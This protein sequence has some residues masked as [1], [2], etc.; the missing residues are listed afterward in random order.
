MESGLGAED[1]QSN[2]IIQ[3]VLILVLVESGLGGYGKTS[4]ERGL[5]SLN[6]CFSGK[7]S[8]SVFCK[9]EDGCGW[10]VLILVLVES[11]LGD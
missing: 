4:V 5:R 1:T 10:E 6:P 2:G 3:S 11:G 9:A 7:W 8:W